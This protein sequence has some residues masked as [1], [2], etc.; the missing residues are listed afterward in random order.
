MALIQSVL[1][2]LPI[3]Y[4]SFFR[5]PQTVINK[6][7]KI[8]QRFLWGGGHDSKKIAWISWE[9]VCLPKDKGGLG[10]KDINTFNLALLGKWMWNLMHQQGALWVAVLEAKYEGWRGLTEE[11]SSNLQSMWWR[12]LKR[13]IHQ[14]HHGKI[15]QHE[16]NWKVEAGDKVKFWEDRWIC[17]EQSLAEK[18]P[19]LYMISA[20]QH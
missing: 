16:I 20:Q 18:Y 5:V 2:S 3:Y 6:L 14:S 19:R 10:I 12:D 4:F 7:I 17:H 9:T 8:Q 15:L 1:T 13:A 11:G